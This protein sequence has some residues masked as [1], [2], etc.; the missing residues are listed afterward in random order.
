ML[1]KWE[2][3][4]LPSVDKDSIEEAL[5]RRGIAWNGAAH[6]TAT[7]P[8][9]RELRRS[10]LYA[11]DLNF[12]MT[13]VFTSLLP[14]PLAADLSTLTPVTVLEDRDDDDSYDVALGKLEHDW[15]VWKNSAKGRRTR[16]NIDIDTALIAATT[17]IVANDRLRFVL[18]K[19]RR[20]MRK[21]LVELSN[22]GLRPSDTD[23]KSDLAK[24][25]VEVWAAVEKAT[26]AMTVLR[27]NL[28]M[29][30]EEFS[31]Q[32]T[33]KS[34][35]LLEVI[36]TVL[37][38]FFGPKTGRRTI[39]HHGFY[40]YSAAQWAMFR[41]LRQLPDVDQYFV[42]HDDGT[43]PVFE[44][45]RQFFSERWEMPRAAPESTGRAPTLLAR[46]FRGALRGEKVDPSLIGDSVRIIACRNPSEFVR[47]RAKEVR[48]DRDD[49]HRTS[50]LFAPANKEL[51]RV[52]NRLGGLEQGGS[53]DLTQLPVGAF[54]LALYEAVNVL[55]DGKIEARFT[56]KIML[57]V[58]GS[59]FLDVASSQAD[60]I[61]ATSAL[62]RALPF[63]RG[64]VLADEWEQRA[65]V[66][67]RTIVDSVTRFGGRVDADDD[68]TRMKV[69]VNNPLRHVPWGDLTVEEA[70]LVVAS[71]KSACKFVAEASESETTRLG[72]QFRQIRSRVQSG[73]THLPAHQQDEIKAKME[74]F[75]IRLDDEIPVDI[76]V[77][78]VR[79]LLSLE[80]DMIDGYSDD[81]G[82][83][84][85]DDPSAPRSIRAL[86]VLGLRRS[87][88][89]VHVANLADGKF[90]SSSVA[91]SW[92][93]SRKDFKPSDEI[94]V[95][96]QGIE[97][98]ETR[99]R[100]AA[101][102]DL[103]LFWLLLDGLD[104]GAKLTMSHMEEFEGEEWNPSPLLT[105][106][107][108]PTGVRP[109]VSAHVGGLLST[110][111]PNV[112]QL[113]PMRS[114]PGATELVQDDPVA[115]LGSVPREA[116]ASALYCGRRFVLQWALGRSGSYKNDHHQ[117]MLYGNALGAL[118]R[119]KVD[120]ARARAIVDGMWRHL[121]DGERA[122]SEDHRRI[123][124]GES[125]LEQFMLTLR[126]SRDKP[127]KRK[128][129]VDDLKQYEKDPV[130][131]ESRA[132]RAA[133]GDDAIDPSEILVQF[134][135]VIP[136]RFHAGEAFDESSNICRHCP[137]RPDCAVAIDTKS[138]YE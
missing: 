136:G 27:E 111:V 124:N 81:D 54:L 29:D 10:G 75:S 48:D 119:R 91:I 33:P 69:A 55:P 98:I 122:S 125:S 132:Y 133:I 51:Q 123:T 49:T 79:M 7:P 57:D 47:Y 22:S 37:E 120:P 85:S 118:Q 109:T 67:H 93:F 21:V 89:D 66:L 135:G 38:K 112:G 105:T 114:V 32:N 80:V 61:R 138:Y 40:F 50:L 25:A 58:V 127:E 45:W 134:H 5:S 30:P 26:P 17:R 12:I 74:G 100:F 117:T 18:R 35:R 60:V 116:L 90:P 82:G 24:A 19:E 42:V 6:V 84:D 95:G 3:I 68:L 34:R 70:E 87:T 23:P 13:A 64:R 73:M 110:R 97:I 62:K 31:A 1:G 52:M 88:A 137:V 106:L 131:P 113:P 103:Y 44:S 99:A 8:F 14:G 4:V 83:D 96:P 115:A 15:L 72:T 108:K 11:V 43:N 2:S 77:D 126:G 94:A 53:V 104:G 63:F 16:L 101:A 76:M 56:P 28:W 102:G 39:V 128:R 59:G 36:E 130:E 46:Q 86:D 41:L 65:V 78:V 129:N 121:T 9:G 71:V 92:P 20:E 107:L